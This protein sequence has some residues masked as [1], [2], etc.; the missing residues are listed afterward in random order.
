MVFYH[1]HHQS[2][3]LFESNLAVRTYALNRPSKLNALDEPMLS[4][5]R[6]KIEV[7]LW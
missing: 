6:P 1:V 5:L 7:R 2:T 3:V 4:L